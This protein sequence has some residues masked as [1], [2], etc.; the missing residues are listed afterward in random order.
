MP[1]PSPPCFGY[2]SIFALT[3]TMHDE[4][5]D[6]GGHGAIY[7]SWFSEEMIATS[8]RGRRLVRSCF[9]S[10][11]RGLGAVEGGAV[12]EEGDALIRPSRWRIAVRLVGPWPPSI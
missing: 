8:G 7:C 1:T 10:S 4:S 11:R 9:P 2:S 6:A 12:E 3:V 5:S